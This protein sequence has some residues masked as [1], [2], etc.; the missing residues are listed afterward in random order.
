MMTASPS[1]FTSSINGQQVVNGGIVNTV[2]AARYAKETRDGAYRHKPQLSWIPP[3]G[4]TFA[5][6]AYQK[7]YGFQKGGS[8]TYSGYVSVTSPASL[9][10]ECCN[11][12]S[13][14]TNY[15]SQD[16]DA[17][18]L[19]ARLK[20]KE[21]AFNAPLAFLEADKAALMFLS[22]ARRVVKLAKAL[23]KKDP[24]RAAAALGFKAV[25]AADVYKGASGYLLEYN[26]GVKP[27]LSD[28][29][30]ACDAIN[31]A[32]QEHWMVTVRG[33]AGIKLA[34]YTECYPISGNLSRSL[35]K[36]EVETGC[37]VRIDAQP[38][39][40]GLITLASLGIT[41]PAELG[42]ELIPFSFVVDWLFPVG[43]YLS[44]L[45]ATLGWDVKGVSITKYYKFHSTFSGVRSG[46]LAINDWK[47]FY[48]NVN[49]SRSC[50]ASVPFPMIGELS[51]KKAT[52]H[53]LA[54]GLALLAG[55]KLPFTRV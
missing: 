43:D 27:M 17:A 7:A 40:P 21:E 39:S 49:L 51:M 33:K 18:L 19:D 13:L 24:K 30:G 8:T 37:K 45:D 16:Y 11:R 48:Q 12:A 55:V 26:Y 52:K 53:N 20:L 54:I 36:Y 38:A 46:S 22:Q 2:V 28:M 47:A 10:T 15:R 31:R 50:P 4:Y 29:F 35:A 42:W 5:R 32:P 3:T 41:N 1:N 44:S 23:R 25:K 9:K 34:G 6:E 14:P